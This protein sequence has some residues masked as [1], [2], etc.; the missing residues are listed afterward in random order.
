MCGRRKDKKIGCQPTVC[1]LCISFV[2]GSSEK[3]N[4]NP[5]SIRIRFGFFLFGAGNGT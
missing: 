2:N 5:K 1:A 4:P 3:E